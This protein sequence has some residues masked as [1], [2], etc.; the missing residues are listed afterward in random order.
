MYADDLAIVCHS[1][2]QLRRAINTIEE[3]AA[4]SNMVV[5]HTKCGIIAFPNGKRNPLAG[6]KEVLLI[7]VVK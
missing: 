7:P 6:L 1:L 5:N 3:W 4:S 2:V